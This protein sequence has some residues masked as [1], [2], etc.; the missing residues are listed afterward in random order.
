M[1]RTRQEMQQINWIAVR[2]NYF[3]STQGL[4]E[5]LYALQDLLRSGAKD[6]KSMDDSMKFVTDKA[7]KNDKN[8]LFLLGINYFNGSGGF[9]KDLVKAEEN[10]RKAA[11]L[12]HPE[13]DFLIGQLLLEQFRNKEAFEFI[14]RSAAK[15]GN[16]KAAHILGI[17]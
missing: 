10:F 6:A 7:I 16:T 4:A 8:A 2:P 15:G 11:D 3:Y 9:E 1:E 14:Q 5:A 12:Q 13:A 17:K